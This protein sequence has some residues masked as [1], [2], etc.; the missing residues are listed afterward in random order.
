MIINNFIRHPK[1]KKYLIKLVNYRI[2]DLIRNPKKFYRDLINDLQALTGKYNYPYHKIFIIGLPKSGTT[3]IENFFYNIP[4]YASRPIYGDPWI[5]L[6]QD[7]PEN[8]FKYFSDKL[9]SYAKTHTN[10]NENN[11]KVLNRNKIEKIIL[12]YRDPRDVAISRY[13]HLLSHPKKLWEPH[14]IDYNKLSEKEGI[15]HSIKIICDEYID[16]IL[17]WQKIAL[18]EPERFLVLTFEDMLN[19]PLNCLQKINLFYKLN[20]NINYLIKIL[21]KVDSYMK[22]GFNVN[23]TSGTR[24]TFRKGKIGDWKNYFSTEHIKYFKK[25]AGNKL[26]EIGYEKNLNW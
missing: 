22:K 5:I 7:L 26:I 23:K 1:I 24:S 25:E 20:F 18:Q 21:N 11:L 12:I 17:R 10:P 13:F 16:W 4:G 3:R 8:A 19:D 15:M 6:N 9:Y 2:I 14:L